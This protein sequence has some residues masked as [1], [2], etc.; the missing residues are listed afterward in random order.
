MRKK[1]TA[2]LAVAASLAALSAVAQ[3]GPVTVA[4]YAFSS[5][6]DV[7][8]FQKVQGAKCDKTW[9]KRKSMQIGVGAGTSHCVFRSSVVADSSD[10]KA[11]A[12]I[13]AT[14]SIGGGTPANRRKKAFVGI[15]ARQSENAG[16]ELRVRPYA[17]S[18]QLFR[19]PKGAGQGPVLFRSGK[20]KFIRP[21]LKA[22]SLALRAFDYGAA[23]TKL[24][25]RING[26][27]VVAVT[28]T[29]NSQPDGRRTVATAGVK[30]SGSGAGVV[31]VF[32]NVSVRVPNPF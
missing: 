9:R 17:R 22:N 8:A 28:D 5:Q 13:L 23:D 26:K 18:W 19:D 10:V 24:S 30:G 25:V 14:A 20:G 4:F 6:G 3:A 1:L 2:L 32:D 27:T 21:K 15:G 29:G 12:E 11:D 7:A 16:Y 31:G